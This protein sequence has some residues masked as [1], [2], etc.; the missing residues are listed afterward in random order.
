MLISFF[1]TAGR[2]FAIFICTSPAMA[3]VYERVQ[4]ASQTDATVLLRGETGTGK[5][6]FARAIHVNS[7]RQARPFVT[8]DCTT[9][10]AQ[11]VESELFGHERGA[12]TGAV[13][14]RDGRFQQAAGGVGYR[15]RDALGDLGDAHAAQELVDP[16][17]EDDRFAVGDEVGFAACWRQS[18][19][20][21]EG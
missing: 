7:K 16:I 1:A 18:R 10:P 15:Q 2:A 19:L 12:F 17:P 3:Q 6:M 21:V 9:L 5:G 11:L 13:Q 20:R 4:L 14:R 8:V